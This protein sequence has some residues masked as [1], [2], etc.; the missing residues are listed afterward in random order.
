MA[1]GVVQGAA[2]VVF[3][4]LQVLSLARDRRVC[5]RCVTDAPIDPEPAVTAPHGQLRWFHRT[6][7][8]G[9]LSMGIFGPILLVAG[10][11]LLHP[12]LGALAMTPFL[13]LAALSL[14]HHR[15]EP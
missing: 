14:T 4:G 2:Q 15:L 9:G 10:S 3:I 7:S 12:V 11:V 6:F 5:L 13:P 8:T 1:A